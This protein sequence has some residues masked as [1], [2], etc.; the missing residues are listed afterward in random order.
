MPRKKRAKVKPAPPSN[1][2]G[3]SSKQ[4]RFCQ[5]LLIDDNQAQAAI[6]AGYSPIGAPQT[7]S[8]VLTNVKVQNALTALREERSKRLNL[9]ADQVLE[10]WSTIA[11]ADPNELIE[12]RRTCCRHC[13][14]QDNKHQR[15][16]AER[17]RALAAWQKAKADGATDPFD[18]QGGLGYDPRKPPQASCPECFG[19]GLMVPFPKDTRNLSEAAKRLYAGVKVTKD[20]I[21]IKVHDQMAALQSVAKHLGMMVDKHKHEVSGKDGA[22]IPITIIRFDEHQPDD[23]EPPEQKQEPV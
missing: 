22:T 20:G 18:E 9:N 21:E 3:L 8:R 11:N 7:A 16:P 19:D 17:E 1:P 2:Y 10:R 12:I 14:G 5:E 4:W 23:T 6:R 13:Y 15:T